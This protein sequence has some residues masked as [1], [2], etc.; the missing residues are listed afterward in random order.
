MSISMP[1]HPKLV[2]VTEAYGTKSHT[3]AQI[4]LHFQNSFRNSSRKANST[5]QSV[6]NERL[7]TGKIS[8]KER[9]T[10]NIEDSGDQVSVYLSNK[11]SESVDSTARQNILL[12]SSDYIRHVT[13]QS[14]DKSPVGSDSQVV[15]SESGLFF[16]GLRGI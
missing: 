11:Y 9:L 8:I 1:N 7:R 14:R 15:L 4:G 2:G 12:L 3:P 5:T 6:T 16:S 13:S 10:R